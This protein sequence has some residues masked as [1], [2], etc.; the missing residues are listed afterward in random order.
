MSLLEINSYAPIINALFGLRLS[1][2][3]ISEIT[4]ISEI[5]SYRIKKE[6]KFSTLQDKTL[7]FN[8]S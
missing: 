1:F 8:F 6:E 5:Q 2:L 4:P 3:Y 7:T